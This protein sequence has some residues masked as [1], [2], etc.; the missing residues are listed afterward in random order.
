VST[1]RIR[2]AW[3]VGLLLASCA[4][5]VSSFAA[6]LQ[7]VAVEEPK[8]GSVIV[9]VRSPDE[10]P[11]PAAFHLRL[12]SNGGQTRV[13]AAAV[14]PAT[15][16][17]E[18]ATLVLICIDR[19][20]SMQHAVEPI[21][22]AL[23]DVLATPRPD[24]RIGIMSFGSDITPLSPFSADPAA[25]LRVIDGIRAEGGRDGKTKLFDAIAIAMSR[26]ANDPAR[27]PKRL[28]VISDGRDEGSRMPRETLVAIAQKRAAPLDA[29]AFGPLA[30][31][32]SGVLASL[33]TTTGGRFLLVDSAP[34]LAD[35]LR[36]G[37]GTKQ[38]AA[39]SVKFDYDTVGGTAAAAPASAVLEYASPGH[40]VTLIPIDTALAAPAAKLPVAASAPAQ[41]APPASSP[42]PEP[43]H[44]KPWI[45]ASFTLFNVNIDMKGLLTGLVALLV[46]LFALR[47]YRRRHEPPPPEKTPAVVPVAQERPPARGG[48][49]IGAVFAPPAPGRPTAWLVSGGPRKCTT[50]FPIEKPLIR[51][52]ADE[53]N[54]LI[55]TDDEFVSRKH[56]S[57]RYEEGTLY[58]SDLG[59][60]NG[61]FRNDTRLA[62]ASV[63][64][65]PGDVVR[66]GRTAYEVHGAGEPHV[67]AHSGEGERRVP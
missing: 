30:P 42:A 58:L 57:I 45:D 25:S 51:I 63:T 37:L 26:L 16:S 33:S 5:F 52:G 54:D 40:A 41:V 10:A 61:T 34:K 55:V 11:P 27:G 13:A 36:D 62:Q 59:S 46:A 47:V 35:A 53:Q 2:T 56:A 17:P 39:Y 18:L 38:P 65:A 20:G 23:A 15:V 66:F 29:I 67:P 64:L 1:P 14:S 9:T 8:P 3:L 60:S 50:R 19:S 7:A 31:K 43:P 4:M 44:A 6:E 24:L 48:T 28:I 49:R 12:A 21:K 22:A 32:W